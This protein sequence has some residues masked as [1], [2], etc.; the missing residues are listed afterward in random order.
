MVKLFVVQVVNTAVLVLL[1]NG[2]AGVS[3]A[4]TAWTL[5]G[6]SFGDFNA[7]WY[8]HVG[9]ALVM[10][11]LLNI[12]IPHLGPALAALTWTLRVCFDRGCSRDTSISKAVTQKEL[13]EMLTG[14]HFVV[15]ERFAQ[16]LSTAFICVIYSAGLPL[17]MPVAFVSFLLSC[18][19]DKL[20]FLRLYRTPPPTDGTAARV[21]MALL[22]YAA[23]PH[24][25]LALWMYSS[26]DVY[27]GG[28]GQAGDTD[29]GRRARVQSN[30]LY[31]FALAVCLL[32]VLLD[33]TKPVLRLLAGLVSK[34][35]PRLAE[36]LMA[37]CGEGRGHTEADE[38]E[39]QYF[40]AI[41]TEL[42]QKR[43]MTAALKKTV[44]DRYES[45]LDRRSAGGAEPRRAMNGRE[46]YDHRCDP[47]LL[48]AFALDSPTIIAYKA[49]HM[50]TPPSGY[51]P[52][53]LK[54]TQFRQS[55]AFS[56]RPSKVSSRTSSVLEFDMSPP[57]SQPTSLREVQSVLGRQ[58]SNM[59]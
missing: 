52:R 1:I 2:N 54:P 56:P 32:F 37:V 47:E 36:V 46:T 22:P 12:I 17:L 29:V 20:C 21:T 49:T 24:I 28:A 8:Q 27:G 18:W 30:Y 26:P 5:F 25:L 59:I 51:T 23:L 11:M 13:E 44:I 35:M 38:E 39:D 15:E 50:Q 41:P 6:G 14:P 3:T 31:L 33:L 43:V 9:V 34:K 53:A 4:D 57:S 16:A 58:D 55:T 48:D 19:V 7:A 40:R 42:L 45:E 10:T